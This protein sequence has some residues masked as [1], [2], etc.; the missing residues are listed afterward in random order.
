M[1]APSPHS[2]GTGIVYVLLATLGWSLSG[3]FVRFLPDLSGFQINCWRGFWMAV[4]MLVYLVARY[5]AGAIDRFR[6]VPWPAMVA[7]AGFFALGST[8]YVTSL[9]LV[10][11]AVISVIGA[12]SPIFTGLF[13]P[14]VTGERVRAA[15]WAA[16]FIAFIGVAII[17]WNEITGG[18]V[19][20]I[21]VCLLVPMSFAGQTVTLR[22]YRDID[23]MPAICIGG[24]ASF[25]ILGAFGGGFEIPIRDMLILA[26]MGPLQLTIPLIFYGLGAKSVPAITLSIVVMLDVVLNPLWSYIGAGET[27][28]TASWIGGGFVVI[29]VVIGVLGERLRRFALASAQS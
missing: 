2:Y 17:G 5:G 26:A 1:T 7:A 18:S 11:T 19:A 6:A 13:S 14:W 27:P 4:A 24:F 20:G 9:T 15:A 16:A 10:A 21:L 3:V 12:S 22:R 29:A 28:D 25:S 23:M 8:L